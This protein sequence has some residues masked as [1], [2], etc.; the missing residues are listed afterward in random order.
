[1]KNLSSE[2]WEVIHRLPLFGGMELPA[3]E[4]LLKHAS[5]K[6]AAAGTVLFLQGDPADRF[7][8]ILDGWMKLVRETR[9]GNPI[10]V[11]V[12]TRGESFAEAAIFDFAQFPVSAEVVS[13][14][15]LL[16]VPAESFLAAMRADAGL[17]FNMLAALSQ[18]IKFLVMQFEQQRGK[19]AP[20]R[21]GNFLLRL[22]DRPG[23]SATLN[24]PY[25]K[26]LI[27]ARLG[28]KPETLSRALARLRDVGVSSEGGRVIIRDVGMLRKFVGDED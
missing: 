21:L 7:Y 28:M 25:D 18:R 23:E 2:D 22:I 10:V 5:V 27:A 13:D 26:T 14:A 17:A 4:V 1:M 16:F 6:N 3:I 12:M 24:L 8:I 15:R 9:E 11:H 19:S 20:Q